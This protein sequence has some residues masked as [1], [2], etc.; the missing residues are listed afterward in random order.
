MKIV[1]LHCGLFFILSLA[2]GPL[3]FGVT[4]QEVMGEIQKRYEKAED[5]EASFVQEYI[6]KMMKGPPR[7]E[8]KVYFKKRGM[9]RWDYKTP[10]QKLISN[11][12]TLWFYQPEE[13]QVYVTDVSRV[14]RER[15][16]LAFLSGQGD[17][18]KD[19]NLVNFN[20]SISQKEDHFVL[21]L[22]PKDEQSAFPKLALTVDKKTYT[23]LQVDV[24]DNLGNVT[25]TRFLEIKTNVGLSDSFFQFTP[26][27]GTEILTMQESGKNPQKK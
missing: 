20:E 13:N 26:P 17:I 11:G 12:K 2:S 8:G 22:A 4:A 9:M 15:V 1:A 5:M 25:R 7:G 19:F 10:N 18:R 14:I 24:Q 23:I 16:P 6:G 21:E 3:A 27:A